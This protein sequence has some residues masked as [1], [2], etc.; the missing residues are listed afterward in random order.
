LG[1][2]RAAFFEPVRRAG[3]A[4]EVRFLARALALR[5]SWIDRVRFLVLFLALPFGAFAPAARRAPG[6]AVLRPLCR[7]A[8][9]RRFV[10]RFRVEAR[11]VRFAAF[12]AIVFNLW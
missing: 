5:R 10:E 8:S 4:A 3:E 6:R 11:A 7:F 2:G 1:E 9:F 12:L